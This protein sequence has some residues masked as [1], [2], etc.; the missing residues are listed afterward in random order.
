MQIH[1]A[2]EYLKFSHAR[3]SAFVKSATNDKF[4]NIYGFSIDDYTTDDYDTRHV[5]EYIHNSNESSFD[6]SGYSTLYMSDYFPLSEEDG[7]IDFTTEDGK[8]IYYDVSNELDAIYK[9]YLDNNDEN[10]LNYEFV[11]SDGSKV[12]FD[13]IQYE[14]INDSVATPVSFNWVLMIKWEE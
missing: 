3:K 10:S 14:I 5:Y 12:I 9:E 11:L 4:E 2:Y 13:N 8:R 7:V 1:S 6:V